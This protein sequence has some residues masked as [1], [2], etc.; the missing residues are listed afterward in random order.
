MIKRAISPLSP[1]ASL[2]G[3]TPEATN[4]GGRETTGYGIDN[5]E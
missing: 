3:R 4:K 2:K 1:K 5:E